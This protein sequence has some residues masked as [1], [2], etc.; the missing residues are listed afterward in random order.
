MEEPSSNDTEDASDIDRR[1]HMKAHWIGDIVKAV[2]TQGKKVGTYVG[3]VA[4]RATGFFNITTEAGT[5]E[6]ISHRYCRPIY[7]VDGYSINLEGGRRFLPSPEGRRVST[8]H[9]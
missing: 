2:V 8:P 3:R 9:S 1:N 4:V 7:R 5:I 6:G